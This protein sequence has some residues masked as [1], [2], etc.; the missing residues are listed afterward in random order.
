M[1][2]KSS[3]QQFLLLLVL[4]VLGLCLQSTVS[5]A[6]PLVKRA[7]QVELESFVFENGLLSGTIKVQNIAYQKSVT[8]NY[9]VGKTW[10]D[11]QKIAASYKESLPQGYERWAFAGKAEGATVFYLRFDA[12][13]QSFYD[14]GNNVNHQIP[15]PPASTPSSSTATPTNPTSTPATPI[16]TSLTPTITEKP[17]ITD[18]AGGV[19]IVPTSL[20]PN[21]GHSYPPE[22]P[23]CQTF[24][25]LDS[26]TGSSASVPLVA[27]YRRWQTP[28]RNSPAYAPSF[29][30]YRNLQ[31]YADIQY[32]SARTEAVVTV[33]VLTRV[34]EEVEIKFG[35]TWVKARSVLVKAG[36]KEARDGLNISIRGLSTSSVLTLDPVY[37]PFHMPSVSRPETLNGQK[38]A[39]VELFGWPFKDI[40]KECEF[41]GKAGYMGVKIWPA[42]EHV[43]GDNYYEPDGQFRPWYFVYQPVSYRL[44]S[45]MGTRDEL[46]DMIRT[47][48]ANG[49][50]V[51]AD[52]VINHMSGNGMDIQNHRSSHGCQSYSGHNGTAGSPFFTHGNT[53][54]LN[55]ETNERPAMEYP[56][57][58]YGP[59]DFHCERSLNSWTDGGVITNG[60]LVGLSD[61]NTES[62]YVQDRIAT[63]LADLLSMGFSGFRIDAAKHIHPHSLSAILARLRSKMGGTFPDDFI[64]W[65]E[66]IMG[67]E[68]DLLF[69]SGGEYS[70]YTNLDNKLKS[71]GL[72]NTDIKKIKIWSSDYPKEFPACGNWV[73]PADRF[74][75]QNDDHDQQ[76]HGSSSRD[77]ADTGSV[78]VKEKDV[79]RHRHFEVQLF[80]RGGDWAI[81]TI[82]SSYSFTNEGGAGFPDGHSDCKLYKGVAPVAGC[83]G[84][85]Y[86]PAHDLASCG[87]SVVQNGQWK[88][89]VYTRVHRDLQIINAMRRWMGIGNAGPAQVG[90]PAGCQ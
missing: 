21:P 22:L 11:S 15:R 17:T 83:R 5:S 45:R 35:D 65:L 69:C 81:R 61:L 46:R 38:G 82:L 77:M 57:V 1:P 84:M 87:Y 31:G 43:W 52:A 3:Y 62:E 54:T 71:L 6:S 76:N 60:W 19:P 86:S 20:P 66:V 13:G 90:L 89:G 36:S 12:A 63:Y 42:T 28:S 74:V 34:K 4:L 80:D 79:S 68:R 64:T 32:N 58:P 85:P 51:Y 29:Q 37:F 78:L 48:R 24:N 56:A 39:I 53:Y 27:E 49:V 25:G 59:L 73:L 16:E 44:H 47:C 2:R 9:A 70:W 10:T 8:V 33:R 72:S 18:V 14:P 55:P 50:R 67:G 41:L 26:C 23:G 75:I 7:P 88:E 30:D 40:L